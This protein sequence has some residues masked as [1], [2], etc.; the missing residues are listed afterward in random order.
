MSTC[1]PLYYNGSAT[2]LLIWTESHVTLIVLQHNK[3]AEQSANNRGKFVY[4]GGK[5][6]VWHNDKID[7]TGGWGSST[8]CAVPCSQ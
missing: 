3:R 2:S 7:V 4:A 6:V 5:F 8:C 1:Q